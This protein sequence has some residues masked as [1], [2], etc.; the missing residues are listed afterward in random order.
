M[1]KKCLSILLSLTLLF[2]FSCQKEAEDANNVMTQ[3][4]IK[5][6]YTKKTY[7]I[8]MRDGIKLYTVVYAPKDQSQKFPFLM[9]RTPYSCRPYGEGEYPRVLS[10]NPYLVEDGYIFVCQDVRGRWMSGG[11]YTNMTPNEKDPNIP[12]ESSDTYDTIEWLLKN[13]PNN[14]GKVGQYGISYPGFYTAAS[15]PDAHPALVASSPQAPIA[16]FFFDDFH[17]NGAFTMSYFAAVP[18]FG[19]QS[20]PTTERWYEGPQ[21]PTGDDYWF[22]LN[23]VTP[24]SKAG[25]YF[26]EEN[27]FWNN[28]INHPNYDEFWQKRNLRPALRGID[29]GVMVVGGWFDAQDLFG[30]LHTYKTIEK[31]NPEAKNT[32][33]MGP[34]KHGAWSGNAEHQVVGDIYY[35]DNIDHFYKKNMEAPFFRHYLKGDSTLNLPEAYMFDTG[36]K[37]WDEYEQWPPKSAVKKKLYIHEDGVLS[38]DEPASGETNYDQYISD[39]HNPVPATES[40]AFGFVPPYQTADQRF[41]ARR[42]DVITF[43]TDTLTE[44]LTIS[45]PMLANL[46]VSTS[47]TGSDWIVKV[48]DVYP[49]QVEEGE[50]TPEGVVLDN[51]HQYVRGGVMRGRFRDSFSDPKPFVPGKVTYVDLPLWDIHHTFKTG[52]RIQIQIQSTWFPLADINPQTYVENIYKAKESD[53]KKATQRVYHTPN[54]PTSLEVYVQPSN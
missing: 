45:G 7:N 23:E 36:A 50:Y 35:G 26:S 12:D 48:I 49:L 33:V 54:F 46:F 34:W 25:N 31:Y 51:Y 22:Y 40:I 29:N 41:T 8:E 27:F 1:N 15:L 9:K 5:S 4:Y 44:P 32:L 47:G 20:E 2:I 43:T 14:N 19:F 10:R 38:M 6:H 11:E 24:L 28:I 39:P 30:A 3:E 52:H 53:F 18:W 42:P 13:I 16:D 17:R 21:I 37:K